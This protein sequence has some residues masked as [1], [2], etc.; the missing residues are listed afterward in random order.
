ML[1]KTIKLFILKV[2]AQGLEID[3][4]DDDNVYLNEKVEEP[5]ILLYAT[6]SF[7]KEK[8]HSKLRFVAY[9]SYDGL[10]TWQNWGSRLCKNLTN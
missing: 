6:E 5:V 7:E 1:Q 8:H 3:V 4:V 9:S 10:Q 2:A